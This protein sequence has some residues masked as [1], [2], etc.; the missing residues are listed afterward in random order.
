MPDS[1]GFGRIQLANVTRGAVLV[2]VALALSA[3]NSS[4]P[5]SA[6]A[7]LDTA[8]KFTEA[9]VGVKE[10]PRVTELK[11]TPKGGGR[12]QVGK[13]YKVRGKW[14]TPTED[15]T[16]VASGKASWY[17]PNFH[18]RLTANGEVYNQYA[19]SA[20]HPTMPL[21]SYA[22]VTNLKNG[23]SLLVRVNDRGPFHSNRVMDVSAKAAELLDFRHAGVADVKIEYVGKA[24]MDGHDEKF[25]LA[26]YRA[27][28][29]PEIVPGATQPGTMLASAPEPEN[30]VIA[31][32][33]E[34]QSPVIDAI[35]QHLDM[36]GLT[37]ASIPIPSPRPALFIE[38][39]PMFVAKSARPASL[40]LGYA[41]E[42]AIDERIGSAFAAFDVADI[43]ASI[44][45]R[46][47]VDPQLA[48]RTQVVSLG[49]F[50]DEAAA[51]YVRQLFAD[52]G[53]VSSQETF[54]G[55]KHGFELKILAGADVASNLVQIARDRGF[56]SAHIQ[57]LRTE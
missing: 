17:G 13:P 5:E 15:P 45:P 12:Y 40:V 6:K 32:A 52:V 35:S 31:M 25:L 16:Y 28:G 23:A 46:E 27:P 7:E 37:L 55:G 22:R 47:P 4:K 18:G 44:P 21:P 36:G 30:Q 51:A 26:S 43:S 9:E 56:A 8:P 14:Y 38:G 24:R 41:E 2:A 49:I 10:S 1:N 54:A 20:A 34:P 53:L 29:T 19:L 50:R 57:P 39:T 11:V 33:P 42:T 48:A 3:C